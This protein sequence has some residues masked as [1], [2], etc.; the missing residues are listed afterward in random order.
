[1]EG[2]SFRKKLLDDGLLNTSLKI[3]SSD[4]SLLLPL[5]DPKGLEGYEILLEDFEERE[6]PES[7]YRQLV[8]V[9]DE[10]V[11]LLPS[12]FD[13][14]GDIAIIRLPD[15]LI[16]HARE[17]G[18][19]LMVVLP[20]L[21]T[22]ALDRGVRGEFR[23]RDLQ[24]VAGEDSTR[25]VHVEFGLRFR[26]DPA[27]V[28][29]NPR[30]ANERMRVTSLVSKGEVVVDMFAGIGP[31]SVTIARHAKPSI[32]YAIDINPEA[33][34]LMRENISLNRV[35]GIVPILGDA[36]MEIR[37]LLCQKRLPWQYSVAIWI[38]L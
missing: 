1:M 2:E 24:V 12:S 29:F 31:F 21:R 25:T 15:E 10:L 3:R 27:R 30:L 35:P 34:T 4:G 5:T 20:R 8:T 16:P 28:Y 18:G 38:R 26:V 11:P 7:D 9:P 19:A 33:V 14:V 36:R 17:V 13:V 23:V 6:M 32:V 22:V 37:R